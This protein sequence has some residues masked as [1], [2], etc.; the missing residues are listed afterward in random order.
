MESWRAHLNPE[1]FSPEKKDFYRF[2]PYRDVNAIR[3]KKQTAWNVAKPGP[4]LDILFILLIALLV[5]SVQSAL[6]VGSYSGAG[7]PPMYG[8][9]EAQRHWM[10]IT[11]HLPPREW[12]VNSTDNDL[13][14][15]GL[16]YPPLTA[17]HSYLMGLVA[18]QINSS[19]VA[20]KSSRGL[21]ALHHKFFMRLTAILPFH[22]IYAP[23]ILYFVFYQTKTKELSSN[24]VF[25]LILA[26]P[27]LLAIDNAHFQYNS[28]SLGLFLVSFLFLVNQRFL[29]GSLAFVMALNYKQ[30]ELYHALPVFTFILAR[31]LKRP[32]RSHIVESTVALLK[33]SSVVCMAFVLLWIPFILSGPQTVLAVLGRIFPFYRGLYE[34]KVA[35]VWCAF[36]FVL[37]MNKHFSLETQVRIS[38]I[39]VIFVTLPS[40]FLLFLRPTLKNFKLSLMISSLAFFLFSFQVH[41]KSVLLAAIPALLLLPEH[42]RAVVWFLHISNTSMFPLCLKDGTG[43]LLALFIA[44]YISCS[45]VT[46]FSGKLLLALYH[47]SCLIAVTLCVMEWTI[48]PPQRYPH[49]FPLLNAMYSCVHFLGFLGYFYVE[50]AHSEYRVWLE[51][52]A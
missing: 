31:C 13:L 20:L 28:V 32:L 33:V 14:Y 10:E 50:M 42:H 38:A 35:N 36:S 48:T 4:E 22:V 23:A 19:W 17:Y 39:C 26:Y 15:W 6:A 3:E 24:T 45:V 18:D 40:L 25:A 12:Y 52:R 27:G 37:R 1:Y 34:D 49:I 9:F 41:E 51:K 21:E 46:K 43:L 7:D 44:Y 8:D 16:D 2:F 29:L 30:M 47:L 11:Y 5:L